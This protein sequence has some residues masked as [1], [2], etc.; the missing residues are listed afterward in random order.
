MGLVDEAISQF[1]KALRG[2]NHRLRAYESL[3]YCFME[4]QQY[5][6]A[7]TVL[8][9]ALHEPGLKDD[10]LVGVL[11]MLGQASEA[12]GQQNEAV[13][14]YQRVFAVDIDF[15]YVSQRLNTLEKVGR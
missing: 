6:V 15:L 5:Q 7:S 2:S 4:K 13:Q 10:H 14:Y 9:R 12:L 1:Q 8:Q 3:G 11:Y